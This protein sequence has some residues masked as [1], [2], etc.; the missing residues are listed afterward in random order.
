MWVGAGFLGFSYI[1]TNDLTQSGVGLGRPILDQFWM[2]FGVS[3]ML[4]G[5]QPTDQNQNPRG[6]TGPSIDGSSLIS[7]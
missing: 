1:E 7:G 6:I 4:L 2:S 5:L 3:S